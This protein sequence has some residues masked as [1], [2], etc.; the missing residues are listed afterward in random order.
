MPNNQNVNVLV[1][2]DIPNNLV[3]MQAVLERPGVTLLT[4]SSAVEAL[5]LLLKHEVALALLDVNMPEIDGFELAALMRGNPKTRAIP[6]IFVTAG[7]CEPT[8]TFRGYQTGAVDFLNKPFDPDILR[9]K[10]DVF[11]ELYTQR[12]Q[13]TAQLAELRE[14]LRINE[15][16]TAVLGHDLRTPLSAINIGAGLIAHASAQPSLAN[17]ARLMQSSARRM[18][19]MIN[20]LLDVAKARSGKITLNVGT[21]DYRVVCETL[22]QELADPLVPNAIACECDGDTG[23]LFDQDRVAQI[24]SNLISNALRHGKH[25]APVRVGINGSQTERVAIRVHNEGFIPADEIAK[26][27]EPY[28]SSQVGNPE[29]Q[30]LGLGLY[31]VQQLVQAHGG[32]VTVCSTEA[33]GTVF[34][35]ILP[36][37]V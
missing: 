27:F 23:A 4:A 35:V 28:Y 3:A 9:S 19:R 10:V 1:V 6:L 16:F 37:R 13:L 21:H 22:I 36:R 11:V 25:H 2:D 18:E 26:V 12:R 34:E 32:T 31:I 15:I 33:D 20:Q 30:G 8:R 7:A 17:A 29:H 14:A 5:E 24:L